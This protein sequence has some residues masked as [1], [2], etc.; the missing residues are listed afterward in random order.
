MPRHPHAAAWLG[1]MLAA[2][3]TIA[4]GQQQNPRAERLASVAQWVGITAAETIEGGSG[5]LWDLPALRQ[6]AVEAM[7]PALA[8][9]ALKPAGPE[10]P[11]VRDGLL[12]RWSWCRRGDCGGLGYVFVVDPRRG[13]LF[14]C[15]SADSGRQ[16]W[17]GNDPRMHIPIKGRGCDAANVSEFIRLN[18]RP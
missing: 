15:R 8:R 1:I 11:V 2:V 5:K 7:G 6:A 13:D 18:T 14:V 17:M 9:E 3:P 16:G 12:L 10:T 4:A